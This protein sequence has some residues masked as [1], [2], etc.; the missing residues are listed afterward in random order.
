MNLGRQTRYTKQS[1]S[2]TNRYHIT[3]LLRVEK[4][5]DS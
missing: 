1:K 3:K 2:K 5:K 4:V